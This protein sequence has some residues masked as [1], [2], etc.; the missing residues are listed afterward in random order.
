M[1]RLGNDIA[2][3]KGIL[4]GSLSRGEQ[5]LAAV[6]KED[7]AKFHALFEK[8]LSSQA[9]TSEVYYDYNLY[10]CSPY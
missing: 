4:Q 10:V 9:S 7:L 5:D 6:V 3:A 2:L 8:I 1:A